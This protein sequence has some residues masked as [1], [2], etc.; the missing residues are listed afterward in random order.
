MHQWPSNGFANRFFLRL[1]DIHMQILNT[2]PFLSNLGGTV[3]L[4]KQNGALNQI[5][6]IFI[7]AHSGLNSPKVVHGAY[8]GPRVALGCPN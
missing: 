3:I 2:E 6:L 1:I 7:I 8:I 5:Y 4:A